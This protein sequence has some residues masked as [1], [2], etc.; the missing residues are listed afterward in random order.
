VFA[1]IGLETLC[2]RLNKWCIVGEYEEW[3]R[4]VEN[5]VVSDGAHPLSQL[6][7][8][9]KGRLP[10]ESSVVANQRIEDE[11]TQCWIDLF[12]TRLQKQL[13]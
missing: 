6:M 10:F 3:F 4:H 13:G 2:A 7:G 11:K 1:D 8:K 12:L 9:L 5:R